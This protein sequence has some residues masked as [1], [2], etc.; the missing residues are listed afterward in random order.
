M[1]WNIL[2][3]IF[4]N[5]YFNVNGE[6]KFSVYKFILCLKFKCASFK[7]VNEKENKKYKN[8]R[9]CIMTDSNIQM[10]NDV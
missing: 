4:C 2:S 3:C 9:E 5:T 6:C 7:H 10:L 8:E 1:I